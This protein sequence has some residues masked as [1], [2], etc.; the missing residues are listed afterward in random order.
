MTIPKE[1]MK[2]L[3]I[4]VCFFG[5]LFLIGRY[6]DSRSSAQVR[7]MSAQ[8]AEDKGKF[9]ELNKKLEKEKK[10]ALEAAEKNLKDANKWKAQEAEAKQKEK[11]AKIPAG[12][13]QNEL[14]KKTD[15]SASLNGQEGGTGPIKTK[16]GTLAF[17][18][19]IFSGATI[20][21]LK[22]NLKQ[23]K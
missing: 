19:A 11:E 18:L 20:I 8:F 22:R 14:I 6:F 16:A 17:G 7:L 12:T 5:A 4:A 10:E 13:E 9:E 21:L 23:A 15:L 3:V 2:Y 1:L